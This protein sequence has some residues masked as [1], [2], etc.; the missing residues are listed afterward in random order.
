MILY[1]VMKLIKI[2]G[3]VIYNIDRGELLGFLFCISI[4]F[5]I[6]NGNN[7]DK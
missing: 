2:M 3:M 5:K 7:Y 1:G 4:K 6:K